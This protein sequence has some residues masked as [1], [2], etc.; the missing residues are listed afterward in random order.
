MRVDYE[1]E[2]A[3]WVAVG[4]SLKCDCCAEDLE[5][6]YYLNAASEMDAM[7]AEH[8]R[9]ERLAAAA[10]T[11]AISSVSGSE[12]RAAEGAM[13]DESGFPC[14]SGSVIE[15]LWDVHDDETEEAETRVRLIPFEASRWVLRVVKTRGVM[16]ESLMESTR[17]LVLACVGT[18]HRANRSKETVS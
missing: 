17:R 6:P 11:D 10:A 1:A 14:R 18:L 15:V 12:Q 5:E 2:D 7:I 8:R 16:M 4:R 9:D 13:Y 3:V